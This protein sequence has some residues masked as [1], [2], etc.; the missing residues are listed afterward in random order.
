MNVQTIRLENW[1]KFTEPKE[2]NLTDGLNVLYG[3]NE[4]G[5]STLI[6]SII[7]TFFSKHTSTS[8]RIKSL[9]PLGTSL[10]PRSQIT[11]SKNGETYRI[12]KGFRE[13]MSLLEKLD[14]DSWR[15]IAEG[16]SADK[17]IL[18]L[19]GGQLSP[20]GDTKPELWGLGQTLWMVQGKPIIND[21]LNDETL[22][23]LQTMVGATIESEKEKIVL[24][25]LRSRFL[26]IFTEKNKT[27]KKGSQLKKMQEKISSLNEELSQSLQNN[28]RKEE[29][30]RNIDD[31][32]ILFKRH[33]HNLQ[34]S[35]QERDKIAKEVEAAREH[36]TNREKLEN[37][38]Q[39]I[40]EKFKIQNEKI[41]EIKKNEHKISKLKKENEEITDLI[42]P[43]EDELS[44]LNNKI[45]AK[46][47]DLELANKRIDDTNAEKS[48]AGIAHTTVMDEQALITMRERFNEINDLYNDLTR[49]QEDYNQIIAPNKT[50]IKK[51]EKLYE[52]INKTNISLQAMGL[53]IHA[54]P[55]VKMSGEILL[56]SEI[57]PFSINENENVSWSAN[58][59]LKLKI[60][61]VGEFEVKSGSQDVKAMKEE[62]EKM[63]TDYQKTVSPFGF[64]ELTDLK[65]LVNAKADKDKEIKRIKADLKK[66]SDKSREKLQEDIIKLENKID[67]NWSQIPEDYEYKDSRNK[68]KSVLRDE[69]S[70]KIIQL[71][72]ELKSLSKA[73]NILNEDIEKDR[74]IAQQLDKQINDY[75]KDSYGK[76]KIIEEI[77]ERLKRLKDDGLSSEDR[78]RKLNQLSVELDQKKRAWQVYQDEIE[79]KEKQPLT[80]FDSLNSKIE[81]I[82]KD[83]HKLEV[84]KAVWDSELKN[85]LNQTTDT[86][87]LE[88]KLEVLQNKE[89]ELQTEAEAL[90]L[91]FVLTTF[92][93]ENTIRELSEPIRI[94]VSDDLDKLLGPKYSLIFNKDMKP[95]SIGMNGEEAPLDVL[96]FGTQEQLWCLFRL[97]LGSILSGNEKQLVVLDDPLVNTDPVRMHHALEILKEYA[98]KMQIIVV[99]C[100]VD[101]YNSLTGANF[102]SMDETI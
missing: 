57:T 21:N 37:E 7:T 52:E 25:N 101:K 67:S 87:A 99:T 51:I 56:D 86:N 9:K 16:D 31:A 58:Q 18:E 8:G 33:R 93:R 102:I 49:A 17:E 27:L 24:N 83:I 80:A 22:S 28:T 47:S 2:I 74:K 85:L 70:D 42:G 64:S 11:F 13:K 23:S 26:E 5:K 68:D 15:K 19:V 75:K 76:S 91:L 89:K 77:I 63:Q 90:K 30:I 4:S 73:R 78:E 40:D 10:Q 43:L 55:L 98:E 14:G 81:R 39:G 62:L 96:S 65:D 97:A 54:S 50:E 32:D 94:K 72:D 82:E 34:E 100:D 53:S 35:S 20:R 45:S 1:K 92:Y 12:S 48:I 66:R 71:E 38:I 3:P 44:E 61:Q 95:E 41:E 59:S 79:E 84:N 46:S 36:Q 69:L 6:D 88:E 60:D 29:L